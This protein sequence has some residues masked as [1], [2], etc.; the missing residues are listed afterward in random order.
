[1]DQAGSF[2]AK[3]ATQKLMWGGVCQGGHGE[4][5]RFVAV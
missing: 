5:V 3:A 1:M 2:N 4:L